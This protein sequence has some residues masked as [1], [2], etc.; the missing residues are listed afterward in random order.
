MNVS[1]WGHSRAKRV[2]WDALRRPTSTVSGFPEYCV[3]KLCNVLFT[4]EL[5]RGRAGAG[6]HSYSLHPGFIASDI[7][8][9]VPWGVRH[10]IKLFLS[11]ND[12]GARTQIW[13][14][15]APEI[16]DQD[17]R[18]YD[19]CREK[20]PSRLAEDAALARSLWERSEEWVA[21]W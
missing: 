9:G 8:R 2:D 1:S 4:K 17:G 14:A 18:Y 21:G 13:C 12:E 11:T 6:V 7:W 10:V 15:T 19:A 16:A 3:S 5:A 20:K